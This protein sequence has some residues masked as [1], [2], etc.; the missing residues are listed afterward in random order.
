MLW[1]AILVCLL[2]LV[3]MICRS[4]DGPSAISPS[5][6]ICI[7][8]PSQYKFTFVVGIDGT[9]GTIRRNDL[10]VNYEI[11]RYPGPDKF[12]GDSRQWTATRAKELPETMSLVTEYV[13]HAALAERLYGFT[14]DTF[15]AGA[16]RHADKIYIKLWADAKQSVVHLL[17]RVGAALYRCT[18]GSRAIQAGV[19]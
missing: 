10:V 2:G 8:D 18:N 7:R 17:P 19:P 1:K 15:Y 9:M 13:S 6:Q 5:F 14:A 11:S 4:A 16:T 12:E 3:P